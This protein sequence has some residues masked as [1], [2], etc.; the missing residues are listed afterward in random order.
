MQLPEGM[1]AEIFEPFERLVPIEVLGKTVEVPENNTILR[2]FQFLSNYTITYGKF[3]WNNDCGN[4][5]CQILLPG[6]DEA[7]TK[8]TCCT[9]VREGMKVVGTSKHVRL[10]LK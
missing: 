7:V 6:R 8:R 1:S 3:C 4:C 10:K 9:K 5:E 2:C